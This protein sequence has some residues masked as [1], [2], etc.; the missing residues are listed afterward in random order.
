MRNIVL[1]AV[2]LH[3]FVYADIVAIVA[4]NSA[5]PPLTKK[6]LQDIYLKKQ[7]FINGVKLLPINLQSGSPLRAA[8]EKSILKMDETELGEYWNEKHYNGVKPPMVQNSA[9]AVKAMVKKAPGAIGYIDEASLDDD[10]KAV[11]TFK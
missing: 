5:A 11:A 8:F 1:I 9:E 7:Q 6:Q 2:I 10:V 3:T 4:K